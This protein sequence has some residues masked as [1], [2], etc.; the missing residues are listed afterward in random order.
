MQETI[1]IYDLEYTA[2]EGSQERDWSGEH[3]YREI[4][5]IGAVKANAHTLEEVEHVSI[6]VRPKINPTL[7]DYFIEL[8][9]ITQ[10]KVD[11]KGM[12]FPNAL[13]VFFAFAKSDLLYAWGSDGRVLEENCK[14]HNISLL[15]DKNKLKNIQTVFQS[16]GIDTRNYQSSTIPKAFG[17]KPPSEAHNALN[18]ARSIRIAL[19]YMVDKKILTSFVER[20]RSS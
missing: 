10:K 8:T 2:W 6:F 5:Q 19:K 15:F 3:E 17:I 7:S 14:M 13:K 16:V 1:V 12:S 4:V 9:H 11:E 18:D 20:K